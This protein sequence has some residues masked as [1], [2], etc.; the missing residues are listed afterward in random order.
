MKRGM[1]IFTALAFCLALFACNGG[2]P[3]G[4]QLSNLEVLVTT[5]GGGNLT[6][7]FSPDASEYSLDIQSDMTEF[8]LVASLPDH[9][10]SRITVDG[11]A[12]KA[13]TEVPVTPVVGTSRVTIVV[14]AQDGQSTTYVIAVSREDIQPVVDKFL[15]LT[16]SDPATGVSM[17]YRL[18]VPENYDPSQVYPLVMFLH[19]AGEVGSDNEKQLTANQGAS[20]WAK[21]EEQARQPS[22]VLAPQSNLYASNQTPSGNYQTTGWTSV[23]LYGMDKP[24]QPLDQLA[25]AYDILQKVRGEYSIDPRRIYLTGL[26]MGGFGTFALAIEHPDEFA[27]LLPICG[28]GDPGRLAA[29]AKI[30]IWVFHAAED[31]IVPVLMSQVSVQALKAAGG[32]PKYTEYPAGTYFYPTAHLSWVPTYANA[33]VRAWLFEQSK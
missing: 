15:K 4:S 21:P 6:P 13:G 8:S 9:S 26:S 24:F 7:A 11:K 20:V 10:T 28:G 25:T 30:P 3:S 14:S 17:G 23:M 2:K 5:G 12:V 1:A 18:Y 33:Q 31:P 16:F 32:D 29:I 27:A 19:G 22:F